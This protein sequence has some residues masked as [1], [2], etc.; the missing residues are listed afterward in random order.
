[1]TECNRLLMAV[2]GPDDKATE[3]WRKFHNEELI[4]HKLQYSAKC[5]ITNTIRPDESYNS[6]DVNKT[7]VIQG[8]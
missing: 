2:S 3:E 6:N 8:C 4:T 1:M 5:N 7:N